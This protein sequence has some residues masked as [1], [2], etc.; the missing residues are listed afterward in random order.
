MVQSK[1]KNSRLDKKKSLKR[2]KYYYIIKTN[3]IA[4]KKIKSAMDSRL[5]WEEFNI[6]N[7]PQKNP[8]FILV[9]K[10]TAN[11]KS[12]WKYETILK[13]QVDFKSDSTISNKFEL[14][15]SLNN[16]KNP[17]INSFL[18]PQHYINLYDINKNKTQIGK[19]KKLFS[20]QSNKK[21]WIFKF[22]YGHAGKNIIV[23]DNFPDFQNFIN[24]I[25]NKHSKKWKSVDYQKYKE[26]GRWKKSNY[27]FEWVLQEY[28]LHPALYQKKKFHIRGYYLFFQQNYDKHG[29]LFH[30]SRIAL[31]NKEYKIGNYLD[32]NIHD[33][34]LPKNPTKN[35]LNLKPHI[36]KLMKPTQISRLE[37][38]LK[39]LFHHITKIN[40]VKCYHT[41]RSCYNLYG[42]DIIL[43]SD[44]KIKL[45]EC[46]LFPAL[47]SYQEKLNKVNHPHHIFD[48][49]LDCILDPKFES[50]TSNKTKKEKKFIKVF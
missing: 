50:K 41:D 45:L 36:Y 19:Y 32:K 48:G 34:H 10:E 6:K 9:D 49:I 26:Y 37:Q 20:T 33:T 25:L 28:L 23:F 12:L 18:L 4:K 35:I 46:N 1:K 8:D 27:L 21:V 44:F 5:I 11:D 3:N 30:N 43:T 22:I 24:S 40:K 31:A 39:F 13:S 42:F 47:P 2:K 38:D 17:R 16:L 15:K 29:Y 14:I 7:P